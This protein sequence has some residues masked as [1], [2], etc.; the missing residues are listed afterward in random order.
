MESKIA[1]NGLLGTIGIIGFLLL[2]CDTETITQLF[3][4]VVL[5]FGLMS[6]A[7]FGLI[8]NNRG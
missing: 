7:G 5:G 1:L 4:A 6:L 2:G 3:C 8:K